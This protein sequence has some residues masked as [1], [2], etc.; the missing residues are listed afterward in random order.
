MTFGMRRRDVLQGALAVGAA[1]ASGSL[2]HRRAEAG[3][4]TGMQAQGQLAHQKLVCDRDRERLAAEEL[5]IHP[6]VRR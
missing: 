5:T 2:V 1:M 4:F 6:A 3:Q